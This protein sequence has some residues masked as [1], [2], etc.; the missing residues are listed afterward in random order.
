MALTGKEIS[1]MH[2]KNVAATWG[3]SGNEARPIKTAKGVYLYEEQVEYINGIYTK[4]FFL[5]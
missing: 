4:D 5:L 2:A 3:K 1:Q